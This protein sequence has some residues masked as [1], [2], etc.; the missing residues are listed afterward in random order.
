MSTIT[1]P[2]PTPALADGAAARARARPHRRPGAGSARRCFGR[3]SPLAALLCLW[4]LT[5][6]GYSNDVLRR[7]RQ[8]GERELEGVVLRLPRPGQLHHRRQAAA[9]AVAHGPL[10]ARPSASRASAI[11][12]P[13]ALC[14]IG[15]VGAALRDRPARLRGRSAGAA[16]PAGA[17][18]ITPITVAIGRVNNPDALLVL[19]LVALRAGS[20]V[21]A[22]ES[23]RT[24]HL[25]V[26]GRGRRPRVHD[27]DAAGLDGRAGARRRVP[28]RR[29][30]GARSMRVAASSRS[31]AWRWSRS[32]AAW[33]LAVSLWPG[34]A[35][36]IGG[37]DGR[38]GLE[39]DPRLQRLR[40]P[41]RRRGRHGRRGRQ[42]RRRAGPVAHVQ[43]A[44][45]RADRVA[46]AARGGRPRRRP[47]GDAPRARGPTSAGPRFVLFGVWALVHVVVFSSPAGHLPPVLRERAGAR[48][49]PRCAGAGPG[50][51]WSRARRL[52]GRPRGAR[53]STIAGTAWLAVELLARTPD[54]APWLRTAIPV[55][56]AIASRSRRPARAPAALP[57][58]LLVVGRAGRGVRASAPGR[59][60]TAIANVGQS[61]NGNN[62]LAG[63][64]RRVAG[65]TAAAWAARPRA[66][67]AWA[68]AR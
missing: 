30:A 10:G 45:R 42:L 14:T 58:A 50:R 60:P 25:V 3:R 34:S 20:R 57:A 56:A 27:E 44:G 59:R 55:A 11:L 46:A 21:R 23:G 26:G 9:L 29:A 15:A 12:L 62:V 63:P 47:V 53:R 33:P 4:N 5:V 7:R 65:G 48:P 51:L 8:G 36:Y 31:R 6:N 18:A 66:W 39:P 64:P 1:A 32:S 22:V 2:R 43:R 35:P 68:A 17:L 67:A 13:Q 49:S 38:L 40:P 24:K 37:S 54:F 52:L 61:L 16:S 28:A 41:H 19:L